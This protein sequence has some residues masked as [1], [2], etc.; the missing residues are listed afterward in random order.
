MAAGARSGDA[1]APRV[2]PAVVVQVGAPPPSDES[3]QETLVWWLDGC[4]GNGEKRLGLGTNPHG[5]VLCI[6]GFQSSRS[7]GGLRSDLSLNRLE[8]VLLEMGFKRGSKRA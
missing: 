7:Q 1:P 8:I 2:A 3:A 5:E 6:T 4:D